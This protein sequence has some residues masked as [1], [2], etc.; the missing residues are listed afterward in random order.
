MRKHDV[1][2]MIVCAV[3]VGGVSAAEYVWDGGAGDGKWSSAANWNPDGVPGKDDTV[4]FTS[5]SGSSTVDADFA[6]Q[7][8]TV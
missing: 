4:R 5:A 2:L 8:N 1:A 6:G 3:A 7:V